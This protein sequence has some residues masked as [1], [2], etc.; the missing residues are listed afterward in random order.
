ISVKFAQEYN[1][2]STYSKLLTRE[3]LIELESWGK[4]SVTQGVVEIQLDFQYSLVTFSVSVELLQEAASGKKTYENIN[5]YVDVV[6]SYMDGETEVFVDDANIDKTNENKIVISNIPYAAQ[7]LTLNVNVSENVGLTHF[8]WQ[9][10]QD[11]AIDAS[12]STKVVFANN[13]LSN[14][15]LQHSVQYKLYEVKLEYNTDEAAPTVNGELGTAEI[16]ALDS[17][18]IDSKALKSNGYK[19]VAMYQKYVYDANTWATEKTN[20]FVK[21]KNGFAQV[22]ASTAYDPA[23]TY[24]LRMDMDQTNANL[25]KVDELSLA[26]FYVKNDRTITMLMVYDYIEIKIVNVSQLDPSSETINK[27]V[28]DF[29]EIKIKSGETVF[30]ADEKFN[31]S[32][33]KVKVEVC[34]SNIEVN[35]LT[36]NLMTGVDFIMA[37]TV[38]ADGQVLTWNVI[39]KDDEKNI[40]SFEIE[41]SSII[42]YV[43]DNAES[44][45]ITYMFKVKTFKATLTTNVPSSA[46]FY[47]QWVG[48][49]WTPAFVM[50][51]S[52]DADLYASSYFESKLEVTR[53]FTDQVKFSYYFSEVY[54]SENVFE[55]YFK[56]NKVVI[57]AGG[58]ILTSLEQTE[59]GIKVSSSDPIIVETLSLIENLVIEL[60]VEPIV[61]LNGA[62]DGTFNKTY[63][64]D[65]D[66]NEGVAQSI[67][68]GTTADCNVQMSEFLYEALVKDGDEIVLDC[69]TETGNFVADMVNVGTYILTFYFQEEGEY[70]WLSQLALIN[71]VKIKIDPLELELSQTGVT[72]TLQKEYDGNTSISFDALRKFINISGYDYKGELKKT[73]LAVSNIFA[74][75]CTSALI[76]DETGKAASGARDVAYNVK[77]EN[78]THT[79]ANFTIKNSETFKIDKC[80]KINRK[81]LTIS[82]IQFYDKVYDGTTEL[83]FSNMG[84]VNISGIVSNGDDVR[85]N[86]E[87][88]IIEFEDAEI[89]LNK[90]VI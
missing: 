63:K 20:L 75:N 22:V 15:V 6:V 36:I 23:Q 58:T 61:Y 26:D 71:Q 30:E 80:V 84:E 86:F 10:T 59:N 16:S 73:N 85:L 57:K 5:D 90:K 8:K 67:T 64:F 17:L 56:I 70:G 25:F 77:F 43:N 55:K 45:A 51:A 50:T 7:N 9:E 28:E 2:T 83:S 47:T 88:I 89:G 29:A 44:V 74:V 1:G 62:T 18:V 68:I 76:V 87:N 27:S 14:K 33:G 46:N 65:F 38:L 11:G 37:T 19:F 24:Y 48:D 66:K 54:G 34:M 82:N 60:Q 4:P 78:L 49:K 3:E 53:K 52:N 81:L 32:T 31:I 39:E 41:I 35:G 72:E 40:F 69:T 12:V 79:N 13:I 42:P 21:T